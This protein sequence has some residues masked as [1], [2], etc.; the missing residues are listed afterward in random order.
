MARWSTPEEAKAEVDRLRALASDILSKIPAY[1]ER[2]SQLAK[3]A[4]ATA[5]LY[6][7]QA[8]IIEE[9]IK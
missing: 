4:R 2:R 5:R 3:D 1:E 8:R 6:R 9:S 7:K